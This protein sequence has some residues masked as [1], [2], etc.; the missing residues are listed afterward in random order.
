MRGETC[1]ALLRVLVLFLWIWWKCPVPQ[2]VL[3]LMPPLPCFSLFV[4][5]NQVLQAGCN[6]NLPI[7]KSGMQNHVNK[8][9][10]SVLYTSSILSFP[11]SFCTPLKTFN[12]C[13]SV[14]VSMGV[15]RAIH[16]TAFL[17][18]SNEA[19]LKLLVSWLHVI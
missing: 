13:L 18:C 9:N 3:P 5:S 6:S 15:S 19:V 1:K 10:I 14:L 8:P 11:F 12:V 2:M 17:S 16:K 7:P 4:V